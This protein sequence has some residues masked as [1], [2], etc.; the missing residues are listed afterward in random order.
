MGTY[1]IIKSLAKSRKLSIAELE[2][3]LDLS[4]GSISKWNTSSPNS[5]PLQKI[6]AY[7]SVS[8]DY[9]LGRTDYPQLASEIVDKSRDEPTSEYYAIQRKASQLSVD[10]QKLLLQM[11]DRTFNDVFKGDTKDEYD[12]GL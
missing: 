5:E 4:N 9:L 7:F 8:T 11:I 6:A 12:S 10:D 2:R 1:D 3:K